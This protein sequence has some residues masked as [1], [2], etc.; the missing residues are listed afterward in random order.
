MNPNTLNTKIGI[1]GGGQ[2]G[3]MLCLA[4]ADWNL[5]I[6]ILD[7]IGCPAQNLCTT[8]VEG[9]I[10]SYED[11][12]AFG[13]SVDVLTIEI[14]HV[15]IDA[16]KQLEKEG[17]KVFPK[18]ATLE[19]INDK[20][21][22]KQFYKDNNIP[23]SAFQIF[24]N[25]QEVIDANLTFPFVQKSCKGGYD[26]KG[27]EVIKNDDELNNL[28]DCP[29]I[30]ESLVSIQKEL[31][32]IIARNESGE[33]KSYSVTEMEFDHNSNLVKFL[34]TPA[35][36]DI[37]IEEKCQKIA[38]DIVEKLDYVGILAV[39]LFL[40]ESDEILVN[41]IAPR[42][43]NSGHHT[44]EGSVTS[45]FQQQL[46]AIL[47]LPLGETVFKKHTAMVNLVGEQGY[48]GNVKVE[49]LEECLKIPDF[50]LHLY[51][52]M[53]TKLNRKMGHATVLGDNFDEIKQKADTV[54]KNLKIISE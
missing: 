11:V 17:I 16:L 34:F 39:E 48:E 2:L 28:L 36:I 35:N 31:A 43:H 54:I 5:N 53:T 23:T 12:L 41:E 32:V 52:K 25:K 40:T 7:S 3:R 24:Q 1:L 50:H 27:V 29:C 15:N 13:R 8:F 10:N 18:P 9:N 21:I 20:S 49:G 37:T 44:I 4:G 38:L 42:T 6:S 19:I 51:D 14:E 30:I 45:Q 26:G 46:R 33:I 47:N 22:Q